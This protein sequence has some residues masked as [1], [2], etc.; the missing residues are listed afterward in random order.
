MTLAPPLLLFPLAAMDMRTLRRHLCA[1]HGV[2]FINHYADPAFNEE[3]SYFKDS[4][5][6][7]QKGAEAYT[8]VIIGEIKELKGQVS[9]QN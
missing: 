9:V 4:G 1:R 3:K 2:P 6:L 7:N 5:H 8:K